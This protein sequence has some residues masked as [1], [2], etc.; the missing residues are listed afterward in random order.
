[1]LGDSG[2]AGA[3]TMWPVRTKLREQSLRTAHRGK[4]R[5]LSYRLQGHRHRGRI[6]KYETPPSSGHL[7]RW[8]SFA[9]ILSQWKISW[10]Y[11]N[12]AMKQAHPS[13]GNYFRPEPISRIHVH[14]GILR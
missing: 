5:A 11:Q 2:R 12:M 9:K 13:W 3:D 4:S 10:K 14:A 6:I 7:P 1:M 8:F